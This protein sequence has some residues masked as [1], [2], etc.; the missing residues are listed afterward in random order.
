MLVRLNDDAL[1]IDS[2]SDLVL[3]IQSIRLYIISSRDSS[4][5]PNDASA[6]LAS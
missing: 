3:V 2:D 5:R 4:V 1:D 6:L